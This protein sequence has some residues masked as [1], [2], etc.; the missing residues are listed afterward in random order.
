MHP[1]IISDVRPPLKHDRHFFIRRLRKHGCFPLGVEPAMA[2]LVSYVA[3]HAAAGL[4][5]IGELPNVYSFVGER[6]GFNTPAA[7]SV[8]GFGDSGVVAAVAA[9]VDR[10]G[11]DGGVSN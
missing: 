11:K 2:R 7:G 9:E 1:E 5:V 3:L 4:C 8:E 10:A 6:A